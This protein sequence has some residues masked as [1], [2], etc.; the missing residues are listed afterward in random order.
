MAG[1]MPSTLRLDQPEEHL[2]GEDIH[3][4]DADLPSDQEELDEKGNVLRI[5]HGDGSITITLDGSPISSAED[6]TPKGWFDNLAERIPE[7]ELNR[8]ADDLL[9][10]VDD[11]IETRKDWVETRAQGMRLLGLK[12]ELPGT[13][14]TSDGAPVEGMS[15]VRHPLLLEAVLRFQA[16]AR[17]EL[18]P[19]DGPVKI[20]DDSTGSQVAQDQLADALEQDLNHYLTVTA[21]EYYPDT[22][23]MLLMLGFGGTSFKKIYFCPI[24]NRPVSESVD[25]GDL[26][27]NQAAT[28]L[29]NARRVTHRI[30]MKPSTVKRMQIIG[31]YRDVELSDAIM[32]QLDAQQREAKAT[33]GVSPSAP[34]PL[35]RDREIYEIC[36]ELN[37]IGH[38]HRHK[39]KD[40]GL[41]IPYVATIDVSSRK[42]LS[43][44]RN[45]EE[46]TKDLPIAKKRFVKYPFIP[47]FG[48]LDIGLVH[49]LGNT[50]NAVTAGWREMLDAGMFASFPGFLIAD[51]GS[52]QQ[53]NIFRVPP[54]GG[55]PVKT[56][57]MK[58]SDAIMPLPYKDASPALM[59]LIQ[60]MAETGQ[61]IGGTAEIQVGEGR[62]DAP[63]GT[64]IA[65][66][67]QATKVQNSVHKRMHAAQAEEFRMLIEC[68]REH[69][70]SFWE[71]GQ[72][73]A[74][75]WDEETF[76]K[77]LDAY[78]LT[79]QA[80]PN[81]ASHTQRIMKVMALKQLATANPS[82]YD[83]IAVDTAALEAIGWSNPQQFLIP[84]GAQ[85]SP[86]PELIQ[87]QAKMKAEDDKAKAAVTTAQARMLDAQTNQK[88]VGL[89]AQMGAKEGG[90]LQPADTP[91]D[92]M[93]AQARLLDAHTKARNVDINEHDSAIRHHDLL[94]EDRN[95]DL[96]RQADLQAH[97]M[98]I[99]KEVIVHGQNLETLGHEHRHDH[100][101]VDKELESK[102]KVAKSKPKPAKS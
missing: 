39:G 94:L 91:A 16:N 97:V 35:D 8:I 70:E 45:Y 2:D 86:P 56:G 102:E 49:I 9:R 96:D 13:Q 65:M 43:I 48:F 53:T 46:K 5:E 34:N 62:Q 69:P 100:E 38:E 98:G 22:D 17:A 15:K 33:E 68:F 57:G 92:Q 60:N 90:G 29:Q 82:M 6:D 23:R 99:A 27:V 78:T 67:E 77:A 1:L 32:P 95:R 28:D 25:A 52:R 4:E 81:T 58:I 59:Q 88:K 21:S 101:V 30:Q 12:I 84:P 72:R 75:K 79:P 20:R 42:I 41:E 31:V 87:A 36:C 7:G 55:A 89:D 26:I 64:T 76:L 14:G 44:I 54:G 19:T 93:N 51:T 63:V 50:T 80:D 66:I 83:P 11:D 3:I 61:R 37:I 47:G 18:L 74:Q 24:R 71:R 10:G 40:S 73:S 85:Q